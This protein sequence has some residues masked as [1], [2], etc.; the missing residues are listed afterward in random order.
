MEKKKPR[1]WNLFFPLFLCLFMQDFVSWFHRNLQRKKE[2]KVTGSC[3]QSK[4]TIGLIR[5]QRK[6]ERERDL[7]FS[8]KER[9][10]GI[11]SRKSGGKVFKL[12]F[13]LCDQQRI[14][15]LQKKFI[16]WK[17]CLFPFHESLTLS[18]INQA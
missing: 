5:I 15:I 4:E 14:K 18:K 17:I 1:Y 11:I 7:L 13:L 8:I 10:S 12:F 2:R 3:P 9:E 6:H 16:G